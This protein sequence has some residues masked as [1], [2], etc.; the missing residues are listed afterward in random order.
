[1]N[2]SLDWD[3]CNFADT[4]VGG[5]FRLECGQSNDYVNAHSM[6]VEGNAYLSGGQGFDS[7]SDPVVW[8]ELIKI[9]FEN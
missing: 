7:I 3:D 1:M 9:G 4:H 8:G 6:I 5:D 2:G